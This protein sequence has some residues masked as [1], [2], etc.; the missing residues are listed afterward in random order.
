MSLGV[1]NGINTGTQNGLYSGTDI[2]VASGTA[3]EFFDVD[4]PR[5]NLLS[6]IDMGNRGVYPIN[7]TGLLGRDLT[8]STAGLTLVAPFTLDYSN[9]GCLRF[10][11]TVNQR[12]STAFTTGIVGGPNSNLTWGGWF[13]VARMDG[14]KEGNLLSRGRDGS[15]AGWSLLL[16][17]DLN[18]FFRAGSVTLSPTPVGNVYQ[19]TIQALP[20]TWYHMLGIY[21]N[22]VGLSIYINGVFIGFQS[23]T[24]TNLRT[25]GIGWCW[26]SNAAGPTNQLEGKI[27]L[28]Y[29]W[30]R[31]LTPSEITQVFLAHKQRFLKP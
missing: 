20:N 26:A 29:A 19:T 8:T 27:A 14:T 3:T 22:G 1:Y 11:G 12:L 23:F 15:G 25:S 5:R 31:I 28:T 17:T 13:Q 21:E 6:Y 4:I 16:G 7:S 18:G 30:E 24:G 10:P 2:G 9:K